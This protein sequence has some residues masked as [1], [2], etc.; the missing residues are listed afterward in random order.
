MTEAEEAPPSGAGFVRRFDPAHG[1]RLI[2]RSS[3]QVDLDAARAALENERRILERLQDVAGCPR[4]IHLDPDRSELI[5]SDPGGRSLIDAGLLGRVDLARFLAIGESLAR[6]L[7]TIHAR[8]V[9]HGAI[10]PD[11]ILIGPEDDRVWLLDYAQSTT[12]AEEPS[13]LARHRRLAGAPA[14]CSPEQTGRM[15]RPI[16]DRTDLYSLGL[17]LY[18]LATGAPPFAE[19]DPLALIHA[20]L[21]RDPESPQA[22]APWLPEPLAR[23][24]LT[25]LAKEPDDRYRSAAGLAH[26]L[27]RLRQANAAHEPLDTVRLRERD[28]PLSPRPPR[29][30]HGRGRE[31]ASLMAAFMDVTEGG[32]RALF[33]TGYAG[34]GKTSLIRE[35]I[36]SVTLNQG[37]FVSGKCEQFQRD[38]PLLAPARS[39][40]WLC[41]LLLAEPDDRVESWRARILSELGADG[42]ALFELIPGLESLLGTQPAVPPLGPIENQL[43][44]RTLL[45]AL[46]RQIATPDQPLVLFLDDLQWADPPTLA[47]I[48][49]LLEDTAMRGL[50][51]IGAYRDHEVDADHP[52]T[53]LL[54]RPTVAGTPP[55]LLVLDNLTPEK[56]ATLLVAMLRL[57]PA[58]AWPL[59]SRLH[60]KTGGNPFFT[61]ELINA[62]HREGA[63]RL[64]REQ[65]R[66]V[67]EDAA[68]LNS[69]VSA[70]L[71]DLLA[72]GLAE[73]P[74]ETADALLAAA[75]LGNE[76]S[77]GRLALVTGASPRALAESLTPVLERGILIAADALALHA[78]APDVWLRFCHDRMQQAAYRLR[79]EARR[80]RLHQRIARR[81]ATAGDP[82]D[83]F[84]AAEQYA[85]VLSQLTEDAERSVARHLF[86]DAARQAQR[87]GAF[88]TAERFLRLGIDLL[89]ADAWESDLD[90]TLALHVELH[91]ILFGQG[92]N[93]EADAIYE[94]LAA[95]VASP[96]QLVDATCTQI[97]NLSKRTLYREA[98]V[99]GCGLLERLDLPVPLDDLDRSLQEVWA[100]SPDVYCLR[101]SGDRRTGVFVRPESALG[102]EL[103]TF[104]R[105]LAAG[106]LE[107]LPD[108]PDLAGARLAGAAKLMESML[109]SANFT[110]ATLVA[111][112]PL[113]GGRLWIEEGYCEGAICP[114]I[115]IGPVI[116]SLRGDYAAADRLARIALEMG[117]SCG[118]DLKTALG[119][120]VYIGYISHWRNPLEASLGHARRAISE[121]GR[122]GGQPLFP[123]IY[124]PLLAALLDTC[125]RLEELEAEVATGLR[126]AAKI[127]NRH[128][129]QIFLVYRQ[130]VRALQGHTTA[131]GGFA[132]V[133][134]DEQAFQDEVQRNPTAC[135]YFHLHRALAAVLFDDTPA[136]ARHAE[137]AVALTHYVQGKYP[138][139]LVNP[140]HSLALI[141]R[142]R[143]TPA[144]ERAP[145]LE[146]LAINQTW[147][148]ARAADAPMNV[149]HLHDLIESERL[150][151]LGEP[152]AAFQASEQ[153]MRRAQAHQRPWHH[154]LIVER[155]GLLHM[156]HGLEH[157]G[158]P[159]L[160]RAY[161]LYRQWGASGKTEAMR[162]AWPFVATRRPDETARQPADDLDQAALLRASEALASETS[163]A[164]LVARVM[165][166]VAQLT[167][168][169]DVRFLA[170]DEEGQW[171]LEGGRRGAEPLAPMT[172]AEA[173][174]QGLVATSVLRLGLKT[175]RPVVSDDAV[176]DSRFAADP[177]F[178]G[179]PLCSLLGLPVVVQGRVSAFLTLENRRL[180]AA[181]AAERVVDL[182]GG[183]AGDVP[184]L[185]SLRLASL[186]SLVALH[187]VLD[188]RNQTLR[189]A[190]QQALERARQALEAVTHEQAIRDRQGQF[191]DLV[192]HE[193][194][195]PLAIMQTNLD[196]LM[197]SQD[198]AHWRDGLRNMD[199]AIQR[200]GEVFDG[201]LRR[202]DW[203]EHRQLCL[204]PIDLSRWLGQRI[205]E[206]RAGWPVPAPSIDLRAPETAIIQADPALLKTALINL[207]DNA[208]KYGPA[209]GPI[210]VALTASDGQAVLGVANDCPLDPARDALDLLS[211]AVRGANSQ[212]IPGLG[213]GLYLVNKLVADQG[214]QVELRRD[215]PER[216][217]IRLI[218]PLIQPGSIP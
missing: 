174:T 21:A 185:Q 18:A 179:L 76:V 184:L 70:N 111:W 93:I 39:L 58:E 199:L 176:L 217:E 101:G 1:P 64:D 137:P 90:A 192:T 50:L 97:D 6:L 112:L 138:T 142:L 95:H 167:G 96:L 54:R 198:P 168:A 196:I 73:L 20:H 51:L 113:R 141:E 71:V 165:E 103:D 215:R 99:L 157:S 19:T 38:R 152:W 29:R 32:T 135:C 121:L 207:L 216:F 161:H 30:L 148:A 128:G 91:L 123:F 177:H 197:L 210:E 89:P 203:G 80:V 136:V 124:F 109:P 61:L 22:R 65:W 159:L 194:R 170:L 108:S 160:T 28:P 114:F 69:P 133:D 129:E 49:A 150:D 14:Y 94:L 104:Y 13:G 83:R 36:R 33:V 132:D 81:L 195:T 180:R 163:R 115:S 188:A 60:G 156:R 205:E 164:G 208:R 2:R 182:L 63:L 79:D 8:G 183:V 105:H 186:G 68:L 88:A 172:L 206:V 66:W 153:A 10:D 110:H 126:L 175:Q 211:K 139:V 118:S 127:G 17:T 78:A 149:G 9:I 155:A 75:C 56:V 131:P 145:L 214:G 116:M 77:L 100:S 34:I 3:G 213:M 7:A 5:L 147:L 11:R 102:R 178:A 193:Y 187:S 82:Q 12:F 119:R 16:D 31:L 189:D 26:D 72:S 84:C 4:L 57:S 74:D 134:F 35:I 201:S 106:A 125:E 117:A 98:I 154:A 15:N 166:L 162:R 48:G 41:Q 52:L 46:V 42:A 87:S 23:V 25:L 40:S 158:R 181:F 92:S 171:R 45:V 143:A 27:Q 67:W 169:T 130:F 146:R 53:A 190:H 43:R 44:L 209:A 85:L 24:I 47:L 55:S 204:E 107:R 122:L 200:L 144:A 59:A 151:A 120:L 218:F 140:L 191:I 212:G 62:L 86:A 173:E 202:G 37:L